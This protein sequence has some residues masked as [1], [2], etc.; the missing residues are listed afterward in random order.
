[1]MIRGSKFMENLVKEQEVAEL[2]KD[3]ISLMSRRVV[4][5]LIDKKQFD[6]DKFVNELYNK[7][8]RKLEISGNQIIY[9]MHLEV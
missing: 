4:D 6:I 5:Y 1:M 9:Q 8:Y 2:K 7:G 3:F